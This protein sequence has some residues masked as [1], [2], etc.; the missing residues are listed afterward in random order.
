MPHHSRKYWLYH[1]LPFMQWK[2]MV[3]RKSTRADLIAGLTAALLVLPQGVEFATIAGM[4]PE[5]GL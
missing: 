5:Y 2:H 4:P 1:L 3:A